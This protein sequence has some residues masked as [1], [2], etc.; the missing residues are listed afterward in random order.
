MSTK[1]YRKDLKAAECRQCRVP[2]LE[3]LEGV[4]TSVKSYET[5]IAGLHRRIV[6]VRAT[7]GW[8]FTCMKRAIPLMAYI[9]RVATGD[10]DLEDFVKAMKKSRATDIM[11]GDHI[12][13]D[14][15]NTALDNALTSLDICPN[16]GDNIVHGSFFDA[17]RKC[18]PLYFEKCDHCTQLKVNCICK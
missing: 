12:T 8:C 4:V 7:K 13:D 11:G 15:G 18:T 9:S 1:K 2:I 14:K 6:R 10:R 17:C 3:N 16:C 5:V